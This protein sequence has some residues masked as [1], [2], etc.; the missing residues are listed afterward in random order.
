M[1]LFIV[2]II[3]MPNG[4]TESFGWA[5]EDGSD[6]SVNEVQEIFRSAKYGKIIITAR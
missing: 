4:L 5:G 3:F 2:V 1:V 6:L